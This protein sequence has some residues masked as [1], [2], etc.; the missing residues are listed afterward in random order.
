MHQDYYFY[1]QLTGSIVLEDVVE[2]IKEKI[3]VGGILN[4]SA[5]CRDNSNA[6]TVQEVLH[7][8]VL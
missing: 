6:H 7:I 4:L 3:T 8:T 5:E 1:Q 2:V